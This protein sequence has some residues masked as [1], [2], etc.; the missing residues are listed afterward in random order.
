MAAPKP[1]QSNYMT[2]QNLIDILHAATFRPD[3]VPTL[4]TGRRQHEGLAWRAAAALK[5]L[6]EV[7]NPGVM[8]T[9]AALQSHRSGRPVD[10]ELVEL[11]SKLRM[12]VDGVHELVTATD[13]AVRADSATRHRLIAAADR[14]RVYAQAAEVGCARQLK[15]VGDEIEALDRRLRDAGLADGERLSMMAARGLTDGGA[16]ILADIKARRTAWAAEVAALAAFSL[17]PL[18]RADRLPGA[19]LALLESVTAGEQAVDSEPTGY[20]PSA[21]VAVAA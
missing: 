20:V 1:R 10:V 2:P 9:V 21:Q 16:A 8:M 17:D 13:A 12:L 3:A 11:E 18:A 6:G 19:L 4:L 5:R 7:S 14:R 15:T